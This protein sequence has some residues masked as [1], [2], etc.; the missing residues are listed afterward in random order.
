MSNTRPWISVKLVEDQIKFFSNLRNLVKANVNQQDSKHY[1]CMHDAANA[2]EKLQVIVSSN[3]PAQ[4]ELDSAIQNIVQAYQKVI[5]QVIT[6]SKKNSNGSTK[7]TSPATKPR[8]IRQRQLEKFI[9]IITSKEDPNLTDEDNTISENDS[10]TSLTKAWA[11]S[12]DESQQENANKMDIA[13]THVGIGTGSDSD[14]N[15]SSKTYANDTTFVVPVEL[16]SQMTNSSNIVIPTNKKIPL[17]ANQHRDNNSVPSSR[18][19]SKT[20]SGETNAQLDSFARLESAN[21]MI[22]S[23]LNSAV[24]VSS[25]LAA[26]PIHKKFTSIDIDLHECK[27]HIS[28]IIEKQDKIDTNLDACIQ[29]IKTLQEQYQGIQDLIKNSMVVSSEAKSTTYNVTPHANN[30]KL[31]ASNQNP[32]TNPFNAVA[33]NSGNP[34][35][36]L[37]TDDSPTSVTNTSLYLRRASLVSNNVAGSEEPVVTPSYSKLEVA[38]AV[39][40]VAA[41]FYAPLALVG[42]LDFYGTAAA[43]GVA[44]KLMG[45]LG[46]ASI[47]VGGQIAVAVIG[48]LIIIG[49]LIY[50]TDK[51]WSKYQSTKEKAKANALSPQLNEESESNQANKKINPSLVKTSPTNRGMRHAHINKQLSPIRHTT[52]STSTTVTNSQYTTPSKLSTRRNSNES[53]STQNSNNA[54]PTRASNLPTDN[55]QIKIPL[56]KSSH[57]SQ[58][59]TDATKNNKQAENISIPS[60]SLRPTS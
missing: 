8:Q 14:H 46:V 59:Q 16:I 5:E 52:L 29:G 41:A 6:K 49:T 18:A 54:M 22:S 47:P 50:V 43:S 23:R 17:Q 27:V 44:L 25:D 48:A 11:D 28:K 56:Q 12:D 51:A 3:D 58:P 24:S 40:F 1:Q 60:I 55:L 2:L 10:P 21:S 30:V 36:L 35:N 15:N 13:H 38:L 7:R 42:V 57:K 20:S 19:R 9:K 34:F 53:I 39:A 26:E 37:S 32:N 4:D 31:A 33:D 45:L